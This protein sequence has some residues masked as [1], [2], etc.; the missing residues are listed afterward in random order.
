MEETAFRSQGEETNSNRAT[1]RSVYVAQPMSLCVSRCRLSVAVDSPPQIRS[2]IGWAALD[3]SEGISHP[4]PLQ[5]LCGACNEE[6]T[7][8]SLDGQL[9]I[10]APIHSWRFMLHNIRRIRLFHLFPR[11]DCCSS[12]LA[13]RWPIQVTG[14]VL[15][16]GSCP[17]YIQDMMKPYT[18]GRPLCFTTAKRLHPPSIRGD[19]RRRRGKE[20]PC[21]GHHTTN[22]KKIKDQQKSDKNMPHL[23]N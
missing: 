12:L 5:P 8:G 14:T 11:L 6:P 1:W 18:P 10:A 13:G 20:M 22:K 7:G 21:S 17:S 19:K 4:R 9:S 2:G 3:P 23:H 16:K 15:W